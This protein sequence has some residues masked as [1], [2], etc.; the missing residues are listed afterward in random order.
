MGRMV[1][2]TSF[3]FFSS[4]MDS[5]PYNKWGEN[6]RLQTSFGF[7]SLEAEAFWAGDGAAGEGCTL[8]LPRSILERGV[9]IVTSPSWYV[10]LAG[11]DAACQ[12]G[13]RV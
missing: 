9:K 11:S 10:F 6:G 7:F 13:F 2:Q 8:V 5:F 1:L 3:G 4:Q 12:L